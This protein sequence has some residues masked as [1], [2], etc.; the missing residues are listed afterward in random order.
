M[1][2]LREITSSVRL[3]S[4][5]LSLRG[6]TA[7]ITALLCIA[8]VMLAATWSA[9][10]ARRAAIESG[11]RELVQLT[12]V[13]AERLDQHM[14]ERFRDIGNLVALEA[15]RPVW[16]SRPDEARAVLTELQSTVPDY[17][18]IGFATPD[19]IVK[20]ATDGLLEGVSVAS[21][22]WFLAGLEA[23]TV[24]DVHDAKL[25]DSYL[26]TSPDE[27][28][29]RFV[30]VAAPARAPDGTLAGV[31]GAHL[32]WRWAQ[33]LQSSILS[34]AGV[35]EGTDLLVLSKDGQV[36]IGADDALEV[37]MHRLAGH[38]LDVPLVINDASKPMIT[39]LVATAGQGAYPGLGWIVAAQRPRALVEAPANAL[40]MRIIVAGLG[41]AVVAVFLA[42]VL[43]GKV[44]RPLAELSCDVDRVGRE[45]T[46]MIIGRQN[47]SRD[48]VQLSAAIRSLQRR[49]GTAEAEMAAAQV[50][51][52]DLRREVQA[53]E[54]AVDETSRR[55]GGDLE[56]LRKLADTDPLTGLLNRRAFLSAASEAMEYYKRYHR[57]IGI[58]LFDIDHFKRVNDTFGHAAGDEVIRRVGSAIQADM[59]GTD[60]VARFGGEEFVVLLREIGERDIEIFADRIRTEIAGI[61]FEA[62]DPGLSISVSIGVAV[63]DGADRDVADTI[64]RADKALYEAKAGGRNQV[65]MAA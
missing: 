63:A 2:I 33:D 5:R 34:R 25:L 24:Q 20:V 43:A 40:G 27:P 19:G 10:V 16:S 12:Q 38:R 37:E 41:I 58:L 53:R 7:L 56:A 18:W 11:Q 49:I 62:I 61:S 31:V 42:W 50:K 6:Q 51:V 9:T 21:R 35:A 46:V 55:L 32:S 48:I 3:F 60:K 15:L 64:Q 1:R 44:T 30:D 13:L 22:P 57:N 28:P 59:R 39:A 45:P 14:F 52:A 47:G 4:N 23:I 17:A 65:A 8:A 26:R 29:F 54:E 36:L